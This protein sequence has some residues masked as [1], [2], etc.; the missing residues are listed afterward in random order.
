MFILCFCCLNKEEIRFFAVFTISNVFNEKIFCE[1]VNIHVKISLLQK[2]KL[3]SEIP[4]VWDKNQA[5]F[6]NMNKKKVVSLQIKTKTK[7]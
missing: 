6:H 3:F 2:R 7:K 4:N 5:R 1:N